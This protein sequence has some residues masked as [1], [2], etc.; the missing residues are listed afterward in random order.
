MFML[1]EVL[2]II[3]V[4]SLVIVVSGFQSGLR[5]EHS[6]ATKFKVRIENISNPDEQTA[7]NGT[8][9]P[10]ALSPGVWVLHNRNTPLFTTEKHDRGEACANNPG[11]YAY[12]QEMRL[13]LPGNELF[14]GADK[15]QNGYNLPV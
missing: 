14:L 13:E 3:S 11:L 4:V 12:F 2:H 8:K 5:A 1:R 15:V 9:W 7:S 10:F 6:G